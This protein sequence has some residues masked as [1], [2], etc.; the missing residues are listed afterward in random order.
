MDE[1]S[2]LG[3]A[4]A[5]S[6]RLADGT[7]LLEKYPEKYSNVLSDWIALLIAEEKA[8]LS[9]KQTPKTYP[10]DI[11][12]GDDDQLDWAQRW[13]TDRHYL[14]HPVDPRARPMGYLAWMGGVVVG[15]IMVGIPHATR[16]AG[17]WGYLDL[18]TQWQVVDLCRIWI[19]PELQAGGDW[20]TP[21]LVPGF[22]DRK[23]VF[24]S[25]LATWFISEV[26]QRVQRDR[27][28]LWP[29]V[30]PD[31]PYHIRLAISYH[32]PAYHRGTIYRSM[33]WLPMYFTLDNVLRSLLAHHEAAALGSPIPSES[34]GKYGWCWPLPEPDWTW[35]DIEIKKPRTMRLF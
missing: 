19:R 20:C 10:I 17:W 23:E 25:T 12:L 5:G 26:L 8:K 13:G 21:D 31:Q 29:P 30:Y 32:D 3:K 22:V 24:R 6:G 14:H 34:S 35:Q 11:R 28:S 7:T 4:L 27:I 15:L 9:M 16:C 1:G 18:P 33:G 2:I